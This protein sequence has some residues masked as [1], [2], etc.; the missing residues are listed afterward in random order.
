MPSLR[1]LY[2]SD[3][4]LTE[5][6]DHLKS[7]LTSS[8][9]EDEDVR[10]LVAR[11]LAQDHQ[12]RRAS[13][14]AFL[15]SAPTFLSLHSEI[16]QSVASLD[17]LS[18]F[19]STFSNDLGTV[20]HQIATLKQRSAKLD[21][22]LQRKRAMEEPLARLLQRGVVLDPSVV[23]KIFDGQVD[24]SWKHVVRQLE[25]C[26]EATRRPLD[27][28]AGSSR[29]PGIST[30]RRRSGFVPTLSSIASNGSGESSNTMS[31]LAPDASNQEAYR[32]LAEARSISEACKTVAA[33]KIRSHLV[34]PFN[35]LRTSVTTNLQVLQ[36]SVL[37]AHHQPL[38]AFLARQMPRVAIDVQR[39]YVAA[40]RLY[41]ETGF[42]RYVRSLGQIRK[43]GYKDAVGSGSGTIADAPAS[44][45]GIA[46]LLGG[47][48]SGKGAKGKA[49][50]PYLTD[51]A[52]LANAA[53][54]DDE[55]SP[56]VALGYMGD[57]ASYTASPEALYRSLSLVFF[58]NACSEF[59]FLVRY[60][61]ALPSATTS[62][63]GRSG[64]A[65]TLKRQSGAAAQMRSRSGSTMT[66]SGPFSPSS[67]GPPTPI[68]ESWP[69]GDWSIDEGDEDESIA[70]SEI[71]V[72]DPGSLVQLTQVEQKLLKGRGA[73]AELFRKIFEPVIGTWLN[74]SRALLYGSSM[75]ST[76]TI[77][78]PSNAAPGA[79]TSA[80]HATSSLAGLSST[81]TGGAAGLDV[82]TVGALPLMPLLTMLRLT[83]QLL[84]LA[85]KRGVGSVLTAPL[86]QFKMEAWPLAQRRFGVEIDAVLK[87][88]GQGGKGSASSNSGGW[89]GGAFG[90]S[91]SS[92]KEAALQAVSEDHVLLIVARY[93]SLFSQIAALTSSTSTSAADVGT[94]DAGK[95]SE[96]PSSHMLTSSLMRLRSA[97]ETLVQ[98]KARLLISAGPGKNDT[99]TGKRLVESAARKVRL[100]LMGTGVSSPGP[101]ATREVSWWMDW[102]KKW[103]RK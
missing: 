34:S 33:S 90:S 72:H 94:D 23:D 1:R 31:A 17:T 71:E 30:E 26:I 35:L 64:L 61:E 65:S 45:G 50:D 60:F 92:N 66:A 63:S 75:G 6:A 52:R 57:D 16:D 85:E 18:S 24:Q 53:L 3:L 25:R 62:R 55:S 76:S 102:E 95:G 67:S 2:L 100:E 68:S 84:D 37:L 74:F 8:S 73:S 83:D 20:S 99:G 42:R 38:Y 44:S 7:L 29:G 9:D 86:L 21:E 89:F 36:T 101:K 41:F 93:A 14:D 11:L 49:A 56:P 19:L 54:S 13:R 80:V 98:A 96:D 97:I 78:S 12:D 27:Q 46:S 82:A 91:S 77:S 22:E 28:I 39:A 48:G 59:T 43:R 81:L 69:E 58:D 32:A 10:Q 103:D 51:P 87:L 79:G 47:G 5:S 70:P 4:D 40:A 88:A 15:S